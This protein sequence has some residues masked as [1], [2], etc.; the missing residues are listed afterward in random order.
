[1]WF[2][3]GSD[4]RSAR[5]GAVETQF[6]I[7]GVVSKRVSFLLQFWMHF[8][9]ISR[10]NPLKRHFKIELENKSCKRV[11]FFYILALSGTLLDTLWPVFLCVWGVGA[12]KEAR[13]SRAWGPGLPK[14]GVSLCLV[15]L[16]LETYRFSRVG[17][18]GPLR[19]TE[20]DYLT[21]SPLA[22]GGRPS[23]RKPNQSTL[24]LEQ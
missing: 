15:P 16:A 14:D 17:R 7:F 21:C 20:Y 22:L 13:F 1:M 8:W 10:R 5:A 12:L 19:K 18:Q 23:K 24:N 3:G 6:S 9:Y 11:R 2:S 4:P